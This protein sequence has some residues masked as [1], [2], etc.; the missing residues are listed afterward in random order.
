MRKLIHFFHQLRC[1]HD[2]EFISEKPRWDDDGG[3]GGG[4]FVGTTRIYVC[5]KCGYVHKVNI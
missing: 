2:L 1:K 5:K 4:D 3:H